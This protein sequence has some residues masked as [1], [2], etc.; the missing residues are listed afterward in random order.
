MNKIYAYLY[1]I[2][3]YLCIIRYQDFKR[4][5]VPEKLL[6]ILLDKEEKSL[7]GCAAPLKIC[8]DCTVRKILND[9]KK[10]IDLETSLGKVSLGNAKL[11]LAMG[12]LPPTTLMLNSF[13][14]LTNI[15]K[16]YTACFSILSSLTYST[17]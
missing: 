10:A 15:G 17:T 11:I 6:E 7:K 8:I 13:P 3:M 1:D 5:S 16:R 9:G 12:T 14:Q 4:D 2:I